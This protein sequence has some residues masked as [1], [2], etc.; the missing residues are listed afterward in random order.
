MSYTQAVR[1]N[2]P[3]Y[4]PAYENVLARAGI[5]VHQHLIQARISNTCQELYAT[6]LDGEDELPEH[7]LFED[8]LVLG[9][10]ESVRRRNEARA[11]RDITPLIVPS[12]E[13]LYA[14]RGILHPQHLI[15]EINDE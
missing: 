6:L 4:T 1:K 10:M 11:V 7:S 8:E 3:L 14:R 9:Y 12:P 2:S 13:L 15:E 5:S